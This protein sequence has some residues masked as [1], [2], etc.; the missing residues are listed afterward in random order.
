MSRLQVYTAP[1]E[2]PAPPPRLAGWFDPAKATQ[3]SDPGWMHGPGTG[4]PGTGETVFHTAQDQWVRGYWTRWQ[5]EHVRWY[6]FVTS[7]IAREWLQAHA[8]GDWA[9]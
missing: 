4:Y 7:D 1:A 8:L 5:G 3:W 9:A 6:E 2:A